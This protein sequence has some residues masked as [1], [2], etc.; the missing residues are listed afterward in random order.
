MNKNFPLMNV[1]ELTQAIKLHLEKTFP[2]VHLEGEISNFKMQ[3]SGHLYFS[4][5]DQHAQI[6]AVM[7]K[8][9]AQILKKIPKSGDHVVVKGEINVYPP[10]G[11]YQLIIRELSFV[12]LGE[13]V[14]KR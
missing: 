12:G 14:Q 9:E 11:N 10:K 8:K 3:G 4:L 1:T 7:F 2:F 13:L 5:K 6:S